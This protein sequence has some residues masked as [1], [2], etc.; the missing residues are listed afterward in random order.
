M[1]AEDVC[2]IYFSDNWVDVN[3]TFDCTVQVVANKIVGKC[4]LKLHYDKTYLQF[5]DGENATEKDGDILIEEKID[6][7]SKPFKG[8]KHGYAIITISD[9][10]NL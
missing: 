10:N 1:F 3:K 8:V 6:A 5:I 9:K 4:S 7:N 2:R